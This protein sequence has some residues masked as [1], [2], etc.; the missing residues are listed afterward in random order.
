MAINVKAWTTLGVLSFIYFLE[1]YDRNLIAVSAIPYINYDS[2]KYSL[3]SGT[4]FAIVYTLGGLFFSL[5]RNLRSSRVISIAIACVIFSLA[6]F[7]T[8]YAK[9]FWQQAVIRMIMGLAQSVVTPFSSGII[10]SH[11]DERFRGIA[12]SIFNI[13]VY[14]SFSLILS[15]GT[16]MYD[17]FGWKM[18][19]IVFGLLG[20]VLG[21]C[22]PFL[23]HET[24][25][26]LGDSIPM[27]GAGAPLLPRP[28]NSLCSG[29][30]E[31]EGEQLKAPPPPAGGPRWVSVE[32]STELDSMRRTLLRVLRL[33]REHPVLYVLGLAT[34]LR[35]SAGYVWTAYTSVYFSE[36]YV[37]DADEGGTASS[38]SDC[39]LSF[40]KSFTSAAA[41]GSSLVG[42]AGGG[43]VCD[44]SY[45]YCFVS[46]GGRQGREPKEWGAS[47]SSRHVLFE[48]CCVCVVFDCLQVSAETSILIHGRIEVWPTPAWR[49]T[50]RGYR[51]WA[52][53]WA[54]CWADTSRTP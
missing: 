4:L 11:F 1:N 16:F 2:Y 8:A 48:F 28:E 23:A 19:Y 29:S 6:L 42:G 13:G 54:A 37:S 53:A 46:S 52:P 34:G 3:L 20:I 18:G 21:L 24:G 15:L 49:S 39:V 47:V 26:V 50:C 44:A 22:T 43:T 51:S 14:I 7:C 5:I 12:F 9:L 32:G 40:N 25:D 27:D 45:P 41:T 38:S 35:M 36:L 17:V 33:W 30:A 31:Q 10:G